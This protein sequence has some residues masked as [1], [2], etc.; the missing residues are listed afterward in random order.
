MR[1]DAAANVAGASEYIEE[2]KLNAV[3]TNDDEDWT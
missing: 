2:E 3:E 1:K